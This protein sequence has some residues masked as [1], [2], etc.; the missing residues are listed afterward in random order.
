MT[1]AKAILAGFALTAAAIAAIGLNERAESQQ[2]VTSRY[3]V[4][5]A[6]ISQTGMMAVFHIDTI[7][8]RIRACTIASGTSVV[9]CTP[10]R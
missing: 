6:V 3:A 5:G 4:S 10:W 8:S 7:E 1:N 2:S 9:N